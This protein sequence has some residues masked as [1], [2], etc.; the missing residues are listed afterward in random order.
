L[1]E[2]AKLH[3]RNQ[4]ESREKNE[5]AEF[6]CK[7]WAS[8][9]AVPATIAVLIA[10]G[11]GHAAPGVAAAAGASAKLVKPVAMSINSGACESDGEGTVGANFGNALA[12]N[13]GPKTGGANV[14]KMNTTPYKGSGTYT[15]VII[16][17]YPGKGHTFFGLGTVVVKADRRTGTFVTDD[18]KASGSWDCGEVLK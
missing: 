13:I 9:L 5:M 14:L 11:C 16:S 10:T 2:P 3:L 7:R 6:L 15:K 12:F 4:N 17:G 8:A 18:G 1:A